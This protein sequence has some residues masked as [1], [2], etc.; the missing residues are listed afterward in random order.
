MS[1]SHLLHC[2][3]L[4]TIS[5]IVVYSGKTGAGLIKSDAS[6]IQQDPE[7]TGDKEQDQNDEK[8]FSHKILPATL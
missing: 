7:Y 3:S 1:C 2:H 5:A 8:L 6:R 4:E